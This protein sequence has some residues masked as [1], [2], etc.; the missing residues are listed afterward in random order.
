MDFTSPLGD[1]KLTSRRWKR[2]KTAVGWVSFLNPTYPWSGGA[3]R[4]KKPGFS[5][6]PRT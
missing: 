3:R 4:G 5:G 2:G 1:A 6:G